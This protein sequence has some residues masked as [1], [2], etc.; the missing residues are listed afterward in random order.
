MFLAK[1]RLK[2][3]ETMLEA[4]FFWNPYFRFFSP[5]SGFKILLL[6]VGI[7]SRAPPRFEDYLLTWPYLES[8][9]TL[10]NERALGVLSASSSI[11]EALLLVTGGSLLFV[12]RY[13]EAMSLIFLMYYSSFRVTTS[14][15]ATA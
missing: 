1:L 14:C 9:Y 13:F 10:P 11:L 5:F 4:N 6:T 7:S 2:F 3:L 15:L 8:S 12:V